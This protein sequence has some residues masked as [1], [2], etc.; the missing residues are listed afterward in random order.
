[1]IGRKKL[2]AIVEGEGDE[3]AVPELLRRILHAH[4]R[5][6]VDVL[7]PQ[8]RGDLPKV[9]ANFSRFFHTAVLEEASIIC[10]LDFDCAECIDVINAENEMRAEA[11]RL[12]PDQLFDAC[13]IVKEFESLFLWDPEATKAALPLIPATKDFP[14]NPELIRDAKGWLSDAQPS[15]AAYK[16]TAHQAKIAA[17]LNLEILAVRSPSY[18]RLEAAVLRLTE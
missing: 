5:F 4:N 14:G 12:R 2:L 18:Q 13:F 10:L 1:M 6:D 7:R 16:P 11:Q 17:H 9:K 8:R 15:G 3:R